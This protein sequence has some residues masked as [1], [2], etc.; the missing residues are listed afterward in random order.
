MCASCFAICN[1]RW[2]DV[3]Y[4]ETQKLENILHFPTKDQRVWQ[5]NHI[6]FW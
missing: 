4:L 6:L 1:E 5:N 2:G 3:R